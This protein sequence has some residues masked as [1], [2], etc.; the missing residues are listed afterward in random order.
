MQLYL[1]LGK[2]CRLLLQLGLRL[3][4]SLQTLVQLCLV[5]GQLCRL[6]G[7]RLRLLTQRTHMQ[8]NHLTQ[9]IEQHGRTLRPHLGRGQLCRR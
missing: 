1:V 6:L 5:L 8:H 7:H 4:F 9:L 3:N 2:L